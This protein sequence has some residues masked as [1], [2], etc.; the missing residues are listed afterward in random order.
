MQFNIILNHYFD[1]G[2]NANQLPL[3]HLEVTVV[4]A[5]SA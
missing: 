3:V 1:N 2:H 5:M 4:S